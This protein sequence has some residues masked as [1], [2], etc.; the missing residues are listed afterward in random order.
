[1]LWVGVWPDGPTW[2]V[3]VWQMRLNNQPILQIVPLK[4]LFRIPNQNML[5]HGSY[6][7][8]DIVTFCVIVEY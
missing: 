4:A 3:S 1:M 5:L 2:S 8:L 6:Q 7:I